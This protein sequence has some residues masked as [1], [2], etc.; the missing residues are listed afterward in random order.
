MGSIDLKLT[1]NV[2]KDKFNIEGNAKHPKKLVRSFLRTQIDAG[3]DDTQAEELEE[4]TILIN[5]N[6]SK[7]VFS[8]CNDCGNKG[9]RDGILLRFCG[10]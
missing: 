2:T 5:F 9:L 3:A 1:Y 7:N 6:L 8:V 4:Y 10:S